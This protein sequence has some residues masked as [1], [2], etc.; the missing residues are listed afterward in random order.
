MINS[1]E[2]FKKNFKSQPKN[3]QNLFHA[4]LFETWILSQVFGICGQLQ[5]KQFFKLCF[6]MRAKNTADCVT[7]AFYIRRDRINTVAVRSCWTN[8][9]HTNTKWNRFQF[10]VKKLQP[11]SNWMDFKRDRK[12]IS[13]AFLLSVKFN[14]IYVFTSWL[15][16]IFSEVRTFLAEQLQPL[17]VDEQKEWLNNITTH[18]QSQGLSTPNVEITHVELAI[19]VIIIFGWILSK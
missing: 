13:I 18:I 7:N 3:G 2:W 8:K 12:K 11:S 17:S 14:K 10:W 6:Q 5:T 4:S 16:C 1:I 15:I 9:K 19:K